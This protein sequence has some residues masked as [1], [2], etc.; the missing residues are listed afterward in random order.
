MS[1][2]NSNNG[3]SITQ[4]IAVPAIITLAVTILRL[5][6]ELLHWSPALFSPKVGGGGSLVGIAWLAPIFGIYFAIKLSHAGAGPGSIGR[7]IGFSLL[8]LVIF[9]A[10]G[11]ALRAGES[12][13]VPPLLLLGLAFMAVSAFVPRT[14]WPALFKVLLAYA[15][16]AR[17]PVLVVM[18]F[19]MKGNWGTHY[20]VAPDRFASVGLWTKYLELAVLP[21]MTLWMA[22]TTIL[23]SLFGLV[24]SVFVRR[25]SH[26][27]QT[28]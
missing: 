21:Q 5:V 18:F 11:F 23:G 6:G 20:D 24:A 15:F 14:G 22:F 3:L 27:A 1:S 19:A 9:V 4:L 2:H 17:I 13:A 26:V 10:G 16:A 8:A 7:A 25:P 28:V 12:K